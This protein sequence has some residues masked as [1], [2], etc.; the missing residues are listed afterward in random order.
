MKFFFLI[1]LS[2]LLCSFLVSNSFAQEIRTE[3]KVPKAISFPEPVYGE[4]VKQ[5]GAKGSVSV[6][7]LIDKTGKV[8]VTGAFG[9]AAFCSD[10][11]S[12]TL[13]AIRN[14]A[15]DAA[16]KSVF[17][18][19]LKDGKPTEVNVHL[20][21]KFGPDV[22]EAKNSN[23]LGPKTIS[24]GVINGKAK[25]L[26]K[27]YYPPEARANGASGAV[28]IQVL[29]SEDGKVVTGSAVS[30]HPLLHEATVEAACKAKF[31]RTTL[32]GNPVKVSGVLTYNFVP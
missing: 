19:P 32:Q 20:T 15:M 23:E 28:S 24:G 26:A 9:P 10:L 6:Y 31:A 27:P 18:I 17:E 21:Y 14:A 13:L 12:P 11:K 30:G 2:L 16:A 4:N 22:D 3:A 7:V 29:L 5:Y 8:S 1:Q 25:S